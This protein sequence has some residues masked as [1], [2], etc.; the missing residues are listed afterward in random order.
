MDT[1]LDKK[2]QTIQEMVKLLD[3]N[4]SRDD[5]DAAIKEILEFVVRAEKKTA[6][7]VELLRKAYMTVME[8][9]QG[10]HSRAFSD[11]RGQVDDLFV[12]EKLKK[13][14]DENKT[15]VVEMKEMIQKTVDEKFRDVNFKVSNLKPPRGKPGE[16]GVGRPPTTEEIQLALKAPLE[17][18]KKLWEE[19]V[20]KITDRG[21]GFG[22]ASRI[23]KRL[24]GQSFTESPDGSRTQF[25]IQKIT[26]LSDT[27]AVFR[28]GT[29]RSS[30]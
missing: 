23:Y 17:E 30:G 25:T 28:N 16:N 14:E 29:R 13:M 5:F 20:R 9:L 26:V 11:L 27:V 4:V 1:K 24:T 10:E 12:A 7:E 8:K 22:G 15:N 6:Q 2:L 19:K 21:L 3:K 18:F